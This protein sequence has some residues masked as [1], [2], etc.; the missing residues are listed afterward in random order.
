MFE[1][2]YKTLVGNLVGRDIIRL[3]SGGH[4]GGFWS[5][6]WELNFYLRILSSSHKGS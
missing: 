2:E 3:M 6:S 4:I 1:W 5:E